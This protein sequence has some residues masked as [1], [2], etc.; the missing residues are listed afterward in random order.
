MYAGTW[1]K[2]G[3]AGTFF[4][5]EENDLGDT[6][7][8]G[9]EGEF[10]VMAFALKPAARAAISG[11][12]RQRSRPAAKQLPVESLLTRTIHCARS[13]LV[14][15][16]HTPTPA[17]WGC[18]ALAP[19]RR[20]RGRRE[21]SD[22]ASQRDEAATSSPKPDD[23]D[24]PNR[25]PLLSEDDLFHS[26]TDSPI[27][28]MRERAA[29][30]RKHAYCP[31]PEHRATRML[32]DEVRAKR[33]SEDGSQPPAHVDFECPDCGVPVYCSQE[34]WASDY[35]AHL[36]ICDILRQINEDDHDLRSKRYFWEFNLPGVQL[37]E[38]LVN[39]SN[40]DT[41]FYTRDY[42]AINEERP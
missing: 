10:A 5:S 35:E 8:D 34:H 39:M 37:E 9:Q 42:V 23:S 18:R 14:R 27:P 16:L 4:S 28:Q 6:A 3:T 24:N 12:C 21:S 40:W 30:L 11:A 15:A 36:E 19:S 17:N 2:L 38:A 25:K 26:F 29:F 41:Y 31:H 20:L 7:N 33:V 32:D 22:V 1:G 13:P